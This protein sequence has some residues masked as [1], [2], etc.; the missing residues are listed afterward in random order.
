MNNKKLAILGIIA[1]VMLVLAIIQSKFSNV[2]SNITTGTK[3]LVSGVNTNEIGSII[4]KSGDKTL[5]LE[6]QSGKFVVAN[7]DNYPAETSKIND[8]ITKCLGIEVASQIVTDNPA[9]HTDLGVAED[10]AQMIVKFLNADSKEIV[11]IIVGN[12]KENGS[13]TYV[14]LTSEPK[15]YEAAESPLIEVEPLNYVKKQLCALLKID[16]A[17]TTV[18]SSDGQYTLKPVTDSEDVELVSIPAGKKLKQN[19]AKAVFT[20][21]SNLSFTDVMTKPKD[22]N[23]DRQYVCRLFNSTEFTFDIGTKNGLTYVSCRAAFTEGRPETIRKDETEEQLKQKEEKMLLDDKADDFTA[24]HIGWVYEIPSSNA[25]Y[26]TMPLSGLLEDIKESD[27][28]E[29]LD[30]NAILNTIQQGNMP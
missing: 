14:R 23:F 3:Y 16:T 30:P 25:K 22:M 8:L 10:N 19:E 2:S 9:N 11:G 20:A 17:Q 13:G 7:K 29:T 28:I 27:L 6:Q 12:T 21:L 15:V 1:A 4:I 5:T 26:L 18:S 24:R